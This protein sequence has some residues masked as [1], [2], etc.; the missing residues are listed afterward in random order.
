VFA[1]V[2]EHWRTKR[3]WARQNH[4]ANN[5]PPYQMVMC[6]VAGQYQQKDQQQLEVTLTSPLA[7]IGL[8]ASVW[9]LLFAVWGANTG[10]GLSIGPDRQRAHRH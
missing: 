3:W 10:G 9:P 6:P 1:G 2:R 4:F 8:A 7:R 5:S